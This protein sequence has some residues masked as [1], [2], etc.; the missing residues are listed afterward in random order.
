DKI[1]LD[2]T[3]KIPAS[4]YGGAGDDSIIADS[5]AADFYSGGAGVNYIDYSDRSED[6]KL[7]T[8]NL[9]DDGAANEHDNIQS[10]FIVVTGGTGND[11]ID[12]HNLALG[13]VHGNKGNDT[14]K[15]A[16]QGDIDGGEGDDEMIGGSGA[17]TFYGGDGNDTADYASRTDNLSITLDNVANDGAKNEHDDVREDVESIFGGNGNDYINTAETGNFYVLGFGGNDTIYSHYGDDTIAGGDGNDLLD[18][19]LNPDVIQGGP[20]NDTVTYASRKHSVFIHFDNNYDSGEGSYKADNQ[21]LIPAEGDRLSADIE[22]IYGGSGDD[23]FF[24]DGRPSLHFYGFGGKDYFNPEGSSN[25]TLDGGDGDDQFDVSS[26]SSNLMIGGAGEDTAEFYSAPKGV[27]ISDD[28][29]ANDGTP[30]QNDNIGT[31]VEELGG[32]PHDDTITGNSK[33]NVLFGY[34]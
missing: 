2:K 7:S 11:T 16:T 34:V 6:L 22:T 31:D 14:L 8:N 12:I 13:N 25:C 33:D 3:L 18:G 10:D 26:G 15:G 9:A 1:T 30:G 4:V 17:N 32:S 23:S 29:L 21:Q 19:G 24:G 20:G 28:G 5:P 27:N